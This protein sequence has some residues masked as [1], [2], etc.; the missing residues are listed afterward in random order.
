[1]EVKQMAKYF[2]KAKAREDEEHTSF[3]VLFVDSELPAWKLAHKLSRSA[4]ETY[5]EEYLKDCDDIDVNLR[6]DFSGEVTSK[7]KPYKTFMLPDF[8]NQTMELVDEDNYFL[9]RRFRVHYEYR[10]WGDDKYKKII[11]GKRGVAWE[12]EIIRMD[13]IDFLNI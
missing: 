4:V 3:Q 11:K 9:M 2:C 13:D 12:V 7:E 8:D 1:M 10:H 6:S 5:D